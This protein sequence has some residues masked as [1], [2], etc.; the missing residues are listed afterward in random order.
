M[1][2]AVTYIE[3]CSAESLFRFRAGEARVKL[4]GQREMGS[5][6]D[7]QVHL[8]Q[9][10]SYVRLRTTGPGYG[11]RADTLFGKEVGSGEACLIN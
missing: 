8:N 2:A 4:F 7:E 11:G 1:E 9:N 10:D 6:L 5:R 3:K